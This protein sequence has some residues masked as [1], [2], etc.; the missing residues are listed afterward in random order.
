MAGLALAVLL[1]GCGSTS[2][3]GHDRPILNKEAAARIVVLEQRVQDAP[4]DL[5]A[6]VELA[7]LL[8]G[9]ELPREAR[10][11]YEYVLERDPRRADAAVGLSSVIQ[12][13]PHYEYERAARILERARAVHPRNAELAVQLGFAYDGLGRDGAALRHFDEAARLATQRSTYAAAQLGRLAIY[14]RRGQQAEAHVVRE[15]LRKNYPAVWEKASQSR[16]SRSSPAPDMGD[17]PSDD[18]TG[19][20]PS[21][22]TR[23]RLALEE[24]RKLEKESK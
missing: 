20:H 3:Q 7:G 10:P 21:L 24:A 9:E 4:D 8:L 19:T 12:A 1:T 15:D 13:A 23:F 14:E 11:H 16:A 2:S 17:Q 5:D 6:R 22:A 18:S